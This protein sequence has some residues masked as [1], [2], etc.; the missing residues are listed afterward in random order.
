M[1][2]C[3]FYSILPSLTFRDPAKLTFELKTLETHGPYEP[4]RFSNR[5]NR[6]QVISMTTSVL[7]KFLPVKVERIHVA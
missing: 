5:K 2:L 4:N 3:N 6:R 7:R 1:F